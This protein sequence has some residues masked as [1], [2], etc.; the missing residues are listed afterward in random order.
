MPK[1]PDER[2]KD[3]EW[4]N[5]CSILDEVYWR[6]KRCGVIY[7][8][9]TDERAIHWRNGSRRSGRGQRKGNALERIDFSLLLPVAGARAPRDARAQWFGVAEGDKGGIFAF[10]HWFTSPYRLNSPFSISGLESFLR[11]SISL[12]RARRRTAL[13]FFFAF[14][15]RLSVIFRVGSRPVN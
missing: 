12:N 14:A 2:C 11:P 7:I 5:C 10:T 6:C 9:G 8:G 3:H 1:L 13:R 15:R 4:D